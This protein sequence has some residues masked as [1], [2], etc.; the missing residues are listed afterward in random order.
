MNT[1]Y[2]PT[3]IILGVTLGICIMLGSGSMPLGIISM[4][5]L[6]VLFWF[7]IRALEKGFA[8]GVEIGVDAIDGLIKKLK[9][10]ADFSGNVNVEPSALIESASKIHAVDSIA[11]SC[12]VCGNSL[13]P[14]QRYCGRCGEEVNYCDSCGT[15]Y[16]KDQKYCRG[17]GKSLC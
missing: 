5:G 12:A 13:S 2:A 4:I 17:C 16:A 1:T 15:T 11:I 14:D 8:K 3:G 9:S 10:K 7:G 6:S